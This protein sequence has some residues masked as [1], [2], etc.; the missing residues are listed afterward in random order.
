M[1]AGLLYLVGTM[2]HTGVKVIG[3]QNAVQGRTLPL[4]FRTLTSQHNTPTLLFA[5][6]W[7]TT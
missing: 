4:L 5:R 7:A 6:N 2:A 1:A 3:H